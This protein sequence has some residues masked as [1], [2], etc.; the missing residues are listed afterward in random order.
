MSAAADLFWLRVN[1]RAATYAPGLARALLKA[2]AFLREQMPDAVVEPLVRAGDVGAVVDLVVAQAAIALA[3]VREQLQ[4][5]LAESVTYFAREVPDGSV[6]I[7][8]NVLRPEVITAVR[9]LDTKVIGGLEENIRETVRAYIEQGL[10]TGVNPTETARA[11]REIIGLSPTQLQHVENL[12]T[13]LETGQFADAARRALIDQRFK[14]AN[15]TE[16][17]EAERAARIARIVDRYRASYI[18]FNADTIARTATLDSLKLGQQLAWQDA[19]EKGI[20]D[21]PLMKT[22]K[23]VL[24]DRER[25][26]HVAMEGETVPMDEPYSNGNLI[27]GDDTYNCRCLSIITAAA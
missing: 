18:T 26:E 22:W 6:G 1:R 19:I 11:L 10:R 24:D 13:E 7:S 23:G 5:I 3:P 12:R 17:P 16:L 2:F 15:L 4:G 21:G 20:V 8:F 25:D 9:N 27:P 14:L